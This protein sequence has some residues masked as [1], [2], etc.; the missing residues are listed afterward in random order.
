MSEA[1]K[2]ILGEELYNQVT[3]KIKP[4]EFDLLKNYVPKNRFHEL[5]ETKKQLE[6]KVTTFEDQ[7]NKTKKMLADNEDFKNKYAALEETTNQTLA[8]KDKEILNIAKRS[9]VEAALMQSGAKHINLLSKEIDLDSLSLDG[10]NLIGINDV[11]EKMK[12]G[13]YKD[14]FV[15]KQTQNNVNI[16]PNDSNNGGGD[17]SNI[18]WRA[19]FEKFA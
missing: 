1:I 4:N 6:G 17:P 3:E 16:T 13:D 18:D 7:L 19:E 9:K 5:N 8:A 14:M 15:E 12:T 11:I 2:N 10:D